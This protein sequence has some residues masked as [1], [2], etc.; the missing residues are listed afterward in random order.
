M[1]GSMGGHGINIRHVPSVSILL[2]G[3]S[4]TTYFYIKPNRELLL[5]RK[6]NPMLFLKL[7]MV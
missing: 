5:S 6:K 3:K 7:K 4:F 1:I 2:N